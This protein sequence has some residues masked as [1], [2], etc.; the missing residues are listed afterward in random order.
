LIALDTNVLIYASEI[1]EPEGR[2][3]IALDIMER[4]GEQNAI[5]SLQVVGEY[6]NACRRKKMSSLRHACERAGLW[7]DIYTTPATIPTDYIN[8]AKISEAYNLQ[9]FDALIIVVA[10]RAGAA[11]LL[12]EDMHDGLEVDGL[13]V[14]NPF[15]AGN[16]AVLA[17]Y[18]AAWS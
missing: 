6:I 10:G 11:I 7:M 15:V 17:D 3:L 5:I 2:N 18:F 9:Y 12:S 8:A 4:L 1:V 13:R 16:D 14:V